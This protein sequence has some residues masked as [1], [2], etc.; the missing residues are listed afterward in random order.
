MRNAK[1]IRSMRELLEIILDFYE[2]KMYSEGRD[3]N[4][5]EHC[6]SYIRDYFSELEG[7]FNNV[8]YKTILNL[9]KTETELLRKKFGVYGQY[10]IY[11][12]C[13]M[14]VTQLIE[15]FQRNVFSDVD[16]HLKMYS[17]MFEK[18]GKKPF[19]KKK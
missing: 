11:E 3:G 10:G 1:T 5:V 19:S 15:K 14:V 17:F 2:R 18:Y 4:Y 7:E 6:K 12:V 13:G 9:S 8:D 16:N